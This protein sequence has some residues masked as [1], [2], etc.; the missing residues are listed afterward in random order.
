MIERWGAFVARRARAVLLVGIVTTI[1]AAVYGFGVFGSLSNGGFDDSGSESYA[2]LQAERDS[3]G[4]RSVDVI[5]IYSDDEL[6][7][8]SPEFQSAVED[9]VAGI[10]EGTT[11]SVDPL[12]RGA[13]PG[14]G[15]RGRPRSADP[16]LAGR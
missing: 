15:Q 9:V 10:P 11:S 7:A 13:R 16:D 6:T 2:E 5:A 1:V 14:P 12:L 3:F 8:D 4:N